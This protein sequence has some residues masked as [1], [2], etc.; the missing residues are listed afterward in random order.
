MIV[1]LLRNESN[2]KCY[3]GQHRGT[4]LAKRW[5]KR[6]TNM[7][8]NQ[9]FARALKKYGP[10]AFSRE[11]LNVCSSREE[12]NNLERLWICTLRSYDPK[13]GYN[14]QMGGVKWRAHHT[15]ETRQRISLAMKERWRN[16]TPEQKE[17]FIAAMRS[18]ALSQWQSRT[19]A[20]RSV[21]GAKIKMKL[22]GRKTGR[23]WNRG[24]RLRGG[25]EARWKLSQ[26]MT[27]HWRIK[28]EL[29]MKKPV[30]STQY[31]SQGQ[32]VR[33]GCCI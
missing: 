11:I 14:K 30:M 17:R 21:I 22:K 29:D 15:P 2:F 1:Y 16:K 12:M 24:K 32:G 5:N 13:F 20:E 26:R 9:H 6:F 3:V 33:Y 28:R 4:D 10:E 7:K 18:N 27:A 25:S 8:G 23:S 19:D 31:Q